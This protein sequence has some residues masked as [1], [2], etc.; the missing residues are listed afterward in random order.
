MAKISKA[1]CA[2]YD[3]GLR[4]VDA[5]YCG[6]AWGAA[7]KHACRA[8]ESGLRD[9]IGSREKNEIRKRGERENV[10]FLPTSGNSEA[11]V[12]CCQC[13]ATISAAEAKFG[14]FSGGVIFSCSDRCEG[15]WLNGIEEA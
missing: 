12:F 1:Y 11:A 5:A 9:G 6:E 8:F 4:G 10:V 3:A 14:K 2:G 7:Y 15:N 13:N